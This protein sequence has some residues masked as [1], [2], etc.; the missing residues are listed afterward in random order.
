V[1]SVTEESAERGKEMAKKAAPSGPANPAATEKHHKVDA[2]VAI[3]SNPV[4]EASLDSVNLMFRTPLDGPMVHVS[5][6]L[7]HENGALARNLVATLYDN[8]DHPNQVDRFFD[9]LQNMG[10][11]SG[12]ATRPDKFRRE[13]TRFVIAEGLAPELVAK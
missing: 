7:W 1:I 4:T 11:P 13:V 12:E 10:N 6:S 3:K 5:F 8:E 2:T 9:V